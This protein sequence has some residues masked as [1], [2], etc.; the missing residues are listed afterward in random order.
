MEK[1]VGTCLAN[2]RI[3]F[4]RWWKTSVVPSQPPIVIEIEKMYLFMGNGDDLRV[5]GK[6]AVQRGRPALLR[7][8][9]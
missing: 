8:N 4:I 2:D 7:P 5:F 3:G 9:Y 1:I 6:I